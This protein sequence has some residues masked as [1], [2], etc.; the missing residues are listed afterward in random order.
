METLNQ[1]M[2]MPVERPANKTF[3]HRAGLKGEIEFKDM[4]FSYPGQN[5]LALKDIS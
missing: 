1:V 5:F 2:A 3:L 4:C